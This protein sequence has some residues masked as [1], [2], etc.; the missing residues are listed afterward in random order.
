MARKAEDI[1]ERAVA[2]IGSPDEDAIEEIRKLDKAIDGLEMQIDG[3]CMELLIQEAYAVDFRFVFST[4]KIIKELERVG[5]QS[6]TIA[7]WTPRLAPDFHSDMGQLVDKTREALN[8]AIDAMIHSNLDEAKRVMVLEFQ[9]D[10]I[11]D[12]IIERTNDVAEAFIAK[13]LERIGDLAT[14]IAENVIYIIDA[15]DIRHGGYENPS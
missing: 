3:H 2:L 4:I 14:N 15:E 13:A 6:K 7:K 11:E 10:D 8:A 9:V 12:R 5:D 1:F